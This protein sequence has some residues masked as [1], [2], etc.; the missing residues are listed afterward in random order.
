[1]GDILKIKNDLWEIGEQ[2]VAVIRPLAAQR[3]CSRV[4]I[5][6]AA[7]SLNVTARY[8]YQLVKTYRA[9]NGLLTSLIP[10]QTEGGKG[11]SRLPKQQETV[12]NEVIEALYLTSQ[13]LRAAK[14]VEEVRKRCAEKGI[15]APAGT[16]VRA[17]LCRIASDQLKIRGEKKQTQP[18]SGKFPD[19]TYPLSVI[20]IDH[21]VVDIILVDPLDR[22]PIGRPYITV[23]IDVYS[24]CIAGFVLSLE[25][26][27]AVSV[28]LCLTHVAMEKTALLAR[29]DID[30]VWPIYG[31][32]HKIYVD[33]G[34]D[35]HSMALAR[36]CSK[37][38]IEIGYRPPGQPHYGGIIERVIGTMM[39]LVHTIP[40]TTF[41]N[42]NARGEYDSDKHACLTLSELEHWLMVAITKYYHQKLHTGIELPPLK[43]YEGGVTLMKHDGVMFNQIHNER[44]FLIDF[45]PAEQRLLRRD[46]FMLD[47][48]A[49]YSNALRPM[50]S[51][52]EKYGKFLI[53][54]DPRDLSRIY[55]CLPEDKG[56]L[57]IPYRMLSNP[58]ISL[59]EHRIALKRLHDR[60]K[61]AVD[62][63]ALFRAIDE[64]RGIVKISATKT[65]SARRKR[66]RMSENQKVQ[67]NQVQPNV[68]DIPTLSKSKKTKPTDDMTTF[69]NIEFW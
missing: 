67:E 51:E 39:E 35:F 18:V 24:R 64:I 53:R 44:A 5:E 23:A 9:S 4:E 27:S 30:A 25:A 31:K 6:K 68:S 2:R 7:K 20:Q 38:G 69:T 13:K 66:T 26:P 62:E 21:T 60:G 10:N 34:S 19:V 8:V 12:I 61:Q 47:H 45:L 22:L 56:Y 55:V 29:Y 63:G 43:Q 33:N 41:S 37:H 15:E 3:K 59:F 32:P 1:M 40:G 28:G 49:Y 36:G 46:G 57:E 50:I 48:I 58:A 11:K 65:R 42:V 16:T 17:R 14:I 54:R 52:R